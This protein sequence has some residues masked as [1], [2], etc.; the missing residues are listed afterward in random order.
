[1]LLQYASDLHLEF[2]EN[3]NW[4]QYHQLQSTGKILVLAGDIV[5]FYLIDKHRD[6]FNY[7]SDHFA[8]TYWLPGNHEYYHGDASVRSG[9]FQEK[10]R[11]NV[12][13]ANDTVVQQAG[14][15]IILSTLWTHIPIENEWWI[16]RG[17]NDFRVIRWG[18]NRFTAGNV[19]RLHQQAFHFIQQELAQP[20]NGKT[21]VATHHVPT[22]LHY[23]PEYK[24]SQL[25]DAFAVELFPFIESSG[26]DYWIYGHHHINVPAFKIGNTEMLTN[27]LGYVQKGEQQGFDPAKTILI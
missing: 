9:T 27:Q 18:K 23:P 22:L 25:N 4:L 6:F 5:P 13:L 19:R 21:I 7:I 3:R 15:R 14:I 11:S 12:L 2:S 10:I 17:M 1:M 8:Q 24:G 26:P 20:F 16:E